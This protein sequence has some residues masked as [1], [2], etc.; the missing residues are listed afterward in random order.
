V[1]RMEKQSNV[2]EEEWEARVGREGTG[3][4]IQTH[5]SQRLH[6]QLK[7]INAPKNVWRPGSAQTHWAPSR[8][9]GQA[10]EHSLAAA[11]RRGGVEIKVRGRG[12]DE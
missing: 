5:H 10:K 3:K 12:G 8:S 7:K 6:F 11:L 9:E 1:A 2:L 4:C